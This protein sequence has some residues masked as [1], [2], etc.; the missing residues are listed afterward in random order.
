MVAKFF[1]VQIGRGD[2]V[3]TFEIEI[4][5]PET[6]NGCSSGNIIKRGHDTKVKGQPQHYECPDCE[7]HFYPHTSGFF[8]RLESSINE[9]LFSVLKDGKID[10]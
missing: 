8:S 1:P 2:D 3:S 9:R 10:N 6:L 5:C 4:E 7:R